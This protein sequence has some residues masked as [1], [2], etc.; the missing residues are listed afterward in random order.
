MIS[1]QILPF[2]AKKWNQS[3]GKKCLSYSSESK[4]TCYNCD[5][6]THFADKYPY[7]K[8]EDKPKNERGA[9]PR[10]KPNPIN[11][12]CKKNKIR[13]CK[14]LV[15]VEHTSDVESDDEE[16]GRVRGLLTTLYRFGPYVAL[17]IKQSESLF[18][19][20]RPLVLDCCILS[21]VS[22]FHDLAMHVTQELTP[23]IDSAMVVRF[24]CFSLLHYLV[25]KARARSQ[26]YKELPLIHI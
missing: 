23:S 1:M 22:S 12:R 14:A 5:E 16:T 21:L 18:R 4:R 11:K 20:G 24:L 15:G 17:F 25:I 26:H 13:E 9:N 6:Q 8:R 2:F 3:F 19:G 7:E 10:L